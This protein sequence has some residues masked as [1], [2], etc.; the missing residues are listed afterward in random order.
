MWLSRSKNG[1]DNLFKQSLLSRLKSKLLRKE[2]RNEL[3]PKSGSSIFVNKIQQSHNH[4]CLLCKTEQN[5]QL[6]VRPVDDYL[7]YTYNTQILKQERR[8]HS[9][10]SIWNSQQRNVG[11]LSC[12][13]FRSRLILSEREVKHYANNHGENCKSPKPFF[14]TPK[15]REPFYSSKKR[16]KNCEDGTYIDESGIYTTVLCSTDI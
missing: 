14:M 2:K 10:A 3:N 7:R 16:S 5:F 1:K 6:P 15:P 8:R 9:L 13:E 12:D 11:S 4:G